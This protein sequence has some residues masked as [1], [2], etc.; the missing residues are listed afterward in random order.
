MVHNKQ[1]YVPLPVWASWIAT[2][3]GVEAYIISTNNYSNVDIH[4]FHPTF[5]V[6]N[7]S[8]RQ[9]F[10]YYY[11]KNRLSYKAQ[12][13]FFFKKRCLLNICAEHRQFQISLAQGKLISNMDQA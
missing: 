13:F 6:R 12:S 1:M 7:K 11:F 9:V 2:Y 8:L 5:G 10:F 3:E 4:Y